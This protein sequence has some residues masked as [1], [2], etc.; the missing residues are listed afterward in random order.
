MI[1]QKV[2]NA[3]N[4]C[5]NLLIDEI[6][7]RLVNIDGQKKDVNV[8]F[9]DAFDGDSEIDGI[10]AVYIK[11]DTVFFNYFDSYE[12]NL[13]DPAELFTIDTLCEILSQ[14]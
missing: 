8:D 3:L 9:L 7:D 12:N 6:Y 11:D 10:T 2:I 1:S 13:E 5:K 4:E 14:I